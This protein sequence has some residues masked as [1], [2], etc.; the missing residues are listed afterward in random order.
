MCK[1]DIF[2]G[3]FSPEFCVEWPTLSNQAIKMYRNFR[4]I[5]NLETYLLQDSKPYSDKS[6]KRLT[7]LYISIKSEE[8]ANIL[9]TVGVICAQGRR[10]IK[11]IG[12]G[13]KISN[14]LKIYF[15]YRIHVFNQ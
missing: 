7:L 4:R 3:V 8:C 15:L 2:V 14:F 5:Q 10:S 1:F 6:F 11:I 9:C 13:I 12:G